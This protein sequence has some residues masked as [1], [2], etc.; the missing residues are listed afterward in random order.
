M[1]LELAA[2]RRSVESA[3]ADNVALYEK[4]RYLERYSQRAAAQYGQDGGGGGGNGSRG[5]PA[6]PPPRVV[7]VDEAGLAAE[8]GQRGKA[9]RYQCGPLAFDFAGGGG[10]GGPTGGAGWRGAGVRSRSAHGRGGGGGLIAGCFPED[11]PDEEN[12]GGSLN[13]SSSS[14]TGPEERA[15][16]AY[17]AKVNPFVEF[18]QSEVE[19]RVKGL[20]LHDRAVLAGGRMMLGSRAA[21][22]FIA[23]YA[24]LLHLF[25]LAL[26]YYSLASRRDQGVVSYSD[27]DEGAVAAALAAA[28]AAAA[29]GFGTAVGAGTASSAA[30]AVVA[31]VVGALK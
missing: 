2:S 22:V 27:P 30:A 8:E 21:R 7:R 9:G 20:H 24:A 23:A 28:A 14:N 3:R 26:L 13:S 11:P 16:R 12:G 31:G 1:S 17:E 5:G 15:A 6:Q 18:Q 4:L 19:K 25:I 29:A 10:G